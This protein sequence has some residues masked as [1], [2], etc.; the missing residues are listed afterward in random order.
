MGK[1]EN[2]P[3]TREDREELDRINNSLSI[4]QLSIVY[5]LALVN[6]PVIQLIKYV[7]KK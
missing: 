5:A 6:L 3:F 7:R 1:G 2:V 4:K